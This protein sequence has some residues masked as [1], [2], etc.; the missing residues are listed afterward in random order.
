MLDLNPY[1]MAAWHLLFWGGM[2]GLSFFLAQ[3]IF[4]SHQAWQIGLARVGLLAGLSY[5]H[6]WV[7]V[8]K[9]LHQKRWFMYGASLVVTFVIAVFL[10]Q[11]IRFLGTPWPPPPPPRMPLPRNLRGGHLPGRF[12]LQGV[13][14]TTFALLIST[15]YTSIQENLK[16]DRQRMR[17]EKEKVAYELN[18]LRSQ[19]N[20]HF[21][22]NS[23]NNLQAISI[24][25]PNQVESFVQRLSE[26]LRYV[27][28]GSRQSGV[29]LREEIVYLKHYI[30]FQQS[31]EEVPIPVSIRMEEKG[32]DVDLE[33]MLL[34]VLVENAF[35]HSY[36][37]DRSQRFIDIQL[38]QKS[39][40]IRF[41]IRNN[42][43]QPGPRR[44]APEGRHHGIGLSNMKRRLELLYPGR[45][46]FHYG[47]DGDTYLAQLTLY[48]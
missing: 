10:I 28:E 16:K 17:L 34:I 37:R 38:D 26:M 15:A 39:D 7:L 43:P 18:Y 20:P 8:P 12:V 47:P 32:A 5:W 45:H 24:L 21:I 25:R 27:L 35:H 36:C 11:Q 22:F 33:P 9:L 2:L 6:A 29:S 40:H 46:L 30:F 41:A 48:P 42:L 14:L 23:L 44:L 31:K 1:K 13:F 19:I 3:T 4:P